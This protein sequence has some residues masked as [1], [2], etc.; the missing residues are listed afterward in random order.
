MDSAPPPRTES[1]GRVSW[2][3]KRRKNIQA[4]YR[5]FAPVRICWWASRYGSNSHRRVPLLW[6]VFV[7]RPWARCCYFGVYP[8]FSSLRADRTWQRPNPRVVFCWCPCWFGFLPALWWGRGS[9][10]C[11]RWPCW[12]CTL[13]TTWLCAW[14]RWRLGRSWPPFLGTGSFW[15]SSFYATAGQTHLY[16]PNFLWQWSPGSILCTSKFTA[17]SSPMISVISGWT[18]GCYKLC[19]TP[20][21]WSCW[22]SLTSP[23]AEGAAFL[24]SA[25]FASAQLECCHQL[26]LQ[27][28][29]SAGWVR[30]PAH[31]LV[32]HHGFRPD[33]L[34]ALLSM[35]LCWLPSKYAHA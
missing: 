16:Y 35:L 22:Y 30:L 25:G 27:Q 15:W 34:S 17:H 4:D 5:K 18:W 31:F 6:K 33:F 26:R 24:P 21:R 20:A 13:R 7:S 23:T 14:C 8:S 2:R 19:C 1:Y 12:G 9:C 11:C 28:V 10:W 32:A 29:R 3:T